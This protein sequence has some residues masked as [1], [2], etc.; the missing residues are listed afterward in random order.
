LIE[1]G[2]SNPMNFLSDQKETSAREIHSNVRC[3]IPN[4]LLSRHFT[5]QLIDFQVDP[6]PVRFLLEYLV[7]NSHEWFLKIR[8]R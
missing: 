3:Q 2:L 6:F 8:P 7:K 4:A 5:E 1:G